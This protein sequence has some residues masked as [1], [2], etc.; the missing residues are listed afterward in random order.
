MTSQSSRFRTQS[1]PMSMSLV[2]LST[3]PDAAI[4]LIAF[5]SLGQ[6]RKCSIPVQASHPAPK[7]GNREY[8]QKLLKDYRIE[9]T[10]LPMRGRRQNSKDVEFKIPLTLSSSP[11][12]FLIHEH[13]FAL[14]LPLPGFRLAL[15]RGH[16]WSL[17][18]AFLVPR[19]CPHPRPC[20]KFN[21]KYPIVLWRFQV[22]TL[23][24]GKTR[25]LARDN[26]EGEKGDFW[27]LDQLLSSTT[28]CIEVEIPW[29]LGEPAPT[30]GFFLELLLKT[31]QGPWVQF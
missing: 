21:P 5:L 29:P 18:S 4:S 10:S 23:H 26:R 11:F 24:F 1:G 8:L 31:K 12:G 30:P 14:L 3:I 17:N 6:G 27:V 20:F 25:Y 22:P 13:F 7:V 2:A 15:H 28:V 19:Y 9:R 16:L